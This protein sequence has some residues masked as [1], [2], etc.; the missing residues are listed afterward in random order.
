[1]YSTKP[2]FVYGFHGIDK[3]VAIRI[4]NQEDNFRHS[5]NSYDWLGN[6]IYFWENNYQRAIEYAQEDSKRANSSIK[7]PFVLGA[8][9]DLGNCLD[10]LDQKYINYLAIAFNVLEKYLERENK[11]LPKNTSFGKLDFDF[12][13]R[14]LDCAVIRYA[15]KLA[16]EEGEYFDSVRAAFLEGET[17]YPGSMFRKQNHIQIAIIN[18]NCIKGIFLPR[19]EVP[20]PSNDFS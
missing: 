14:E 1:M 17:L 18:P 16:K 3:E 13:K 10:L 7:T 6:G 5:N 15:H 9:L 4:L 2:S 12:K 11:P 8:I 20:F 19:Q